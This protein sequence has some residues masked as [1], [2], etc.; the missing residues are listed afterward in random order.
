[1][2]ACVLFTVLWFAFYAVKDSTSTNE[3]STLTTL[4]EVVTTPNDSDSTSTSETFTQTTLS[5]VVTTPNDSD[6]TS[7]SETSTQTTLSEVVTTPNDSDST[8]TSETSTQTTLSEVVTTPNDSAYTI[9]LPSLLN[10]PLFSSWG[11]MLLA[12][13]QGAGLAMEAERRGLEKQAV[14]QQTAKRARSQPWEAVLRLG[15]GLG[16]PFLPIRGRMGRGKQR[17]AALMG[18]RPLAPPTAEVSKMDADPGEGRPR[19]LKGLMRQCGKYS[20][21]TSETSTKTT[22]SEVVTTP[23]DSGPFPCEKNPCIYYGATCINLVGQEYDCQCPLGLY[24]TNSSG[25]Q[26]GK[27][28]PGDLSLNN[29]LYNS[30]MEDESTKVYKQLY[31]NVTKICQTAFKNESAYKQTIILSVKSSSTALKRLREAER[32]AFTVVSLINMFDISTTLNNAEVQDLVTKA[33]NENGHSGS[34]FVAISQCNTQKIC[35]SQTTNC[36]ENEDNTIATCNCKPG[37]AKKNTQDNYCLLCDNCSQKD[38]MQCI[39]KELVPQCQCMTDFYAKDGSC[40]ECHF[41]YSG[42]SCKDN[43]TAVIVAIAVVCGIVIVVLAGVLI[44]K[45]LRAK[46]KLNPERRNLLSN[47]YLPTKTHSESKSATNNAP[48]E[49]M[50]PRVQAKDPSGQGGLAR[51]ADKGGLANTAY[52]PEQDYDDVDPSSFEMATRS[53]S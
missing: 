26:Q 38:N 21:S 52:L 28:F 23:N 18:K 49:K 39:I 8:S 25:C 7:T 32:M 45:S 51:N 22:L 16:G 19:A 11:P 42:E 30:S 37:L 1:M 14:R 24:Y 40:Q 27:I 34:S 29:V 15:D 53:E 36:I 20:T 12:P 50:F 6:S 2:K 13:R 41:G 10:C 44:Y 46:K 5:E 9:F 35:D 3:T 47:D 33:L 43:Y 48:R 17:T 31:Y 4:S